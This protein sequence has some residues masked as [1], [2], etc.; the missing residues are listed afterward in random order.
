L[1]LKSG[2]GGGRERFLRTQKNL[3][4]LVPGSGKA[5]RPAFETAV[6]LGKKKKRGQ[7][8][9]VTKKNC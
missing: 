3:I 1:I 9:R 4:Q 8:G 2:G 6:N 5:A 7:K